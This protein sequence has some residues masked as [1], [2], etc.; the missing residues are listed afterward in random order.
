MS[1][2]FSTKANRLLKSSEF[3][4]V[5]ENNNFK[6][7]SRKHL[8]LGK[9]NEGP[10]SRLGIIVSKKNVRLATKRNQLKRIVRETFR[11]TEFT[12]SVDVVFLAQKG[13]MDISGVDLIRTNENEFF[14]LEDLSL[15]HIS[16]PTRPER[17]F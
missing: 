3:Q 12:T 7:Q 17:M 2:T 4:A 1:N 13:I 6:H 14:V 11:K 9:F 10:Q 15:I 5:F 16:E 8:I